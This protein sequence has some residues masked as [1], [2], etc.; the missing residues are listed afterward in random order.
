MYKNNL[1]DPMNKFKYDYNIDLNTQNAATKIIHLVGTNKKVLEFGCATGNMSRILHEQYQCDIIGVE[2]VPEAA[3]IAR[4][5]CS[6]VFIGNIEELDFEKEL[7]PKTFDVIIFADVLE[8]LKYPLNILKK[9]LVFL[10]DDGFV[11]ASIPNIAHASI[12]MELIKGNFRYKS[13]G[14]LDDTHLRFFTKHGIYEL[15]EKSGYIISLMDRVKVPPESTEFK[16]NIQTLP[17][18]IKDYMYKNNDDIE[19]Y[20]FIV[21]AYKSSETG[22]ILKLR[23]DIVK[24]EKEIQEKEELI[25]QKDI[26]IHRFQNTKSWRITEPLRWLN[27]IVKRNLLYK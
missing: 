22:I 2:I 14:L 5:F 11:L 25:K 23:E 20:Q 4:E 18:E 24:L 3:D 10:K 12:I 16:S 7:E 8:H 6:K 19:T 17:R 15:F 21:K 1:H 13:L 27:N 9:I 26:T